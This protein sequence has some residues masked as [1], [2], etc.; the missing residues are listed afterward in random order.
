MSRHG[1]LRRNCWRLEA[2]APSRFESTV[3]SFRH[4][5]D[6][7]IILFIFFFWGGGRG[8]ETRRQLPRQQ[9]INI[10]RATS[11]F[12]FS[13][14]ALIRKYLGGWI[15]FQCNMF[16]VVFSCC[17]RCWW[18]WLLFFLRPFFVW[19]YERRKI[20]AH[21]QQETKTKTTWTARKRD[22][23]IRDGSCKASTGNNR[24]Q[25]ALIKGANNS[26]GDGWT[27]FPFYALF[28]FV[29]HPPTAYMLDPSC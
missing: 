25:L 23:K 10:F 24:A 2:Q 18:W 29:N 27:S 5:P 14:F 11:F 26:S 21:A 1:N 8:L 15:F 12:F 20:E 4:F 13:I 19:L 28:F 17:F 9:H 6:Y 3:W 16:W 22:V 7:Q